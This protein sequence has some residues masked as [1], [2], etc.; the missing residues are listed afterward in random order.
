MVSTTSSGEILFG[1]NHRCTDMIQLIQRQVST[2]SSA[3]DRLAFAS[4]RMQAS[5]IYAAFLL[6]LL[7]S[8]R[9]YPFVDNSVVRNGIQQG[10]VT[11]RGFAL[12]TGD[13][14]SRVCSLIDS[15]S[16]Y[17]DRHRDDQMEIE[18]LLTV[19]SR[20]GANL[21]LSTILHARH[22]RVVTQNESQSNSMHTAVELLGVDEFDEFMN[23][24]DF[25]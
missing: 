15:L 24:I 21:S 10:Q 20:M 4:S 23:F 14:P 16:R 6:L 1:E 13:M 5:L 17:S 2:A 25:E 8:S 7:K 3:R 9:D 18:D 12:T 11:L 19:Q 22:A